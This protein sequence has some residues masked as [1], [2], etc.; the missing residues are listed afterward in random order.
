MKLSQIIRVDEEKCVNCHQCISVCPVKYCNNASG[1]HIKINSDLCIGCGQCIKACSHDARIGLDDFDIWMEDQK[2]GKN[3]V[4]IVAPA[5][6][7]NFPNQYLNIN[8]WLKSLGVKAI[9]DVSFGAELTVKSYLEHVKNNSPECVIAQP[10][11]AL[12]SYIEIYKPEL[13]EYLAPADSPM[14]HTLKMIKNYYPDYSNSKL[15]IISPC[16]T[17]KREFDAVGIGDYNVTMKKISEYFD[18]NNV[19]LSKF[20][21]DDYDNPPAER[22]VLFS[23]PGGLMRTAIRENPALMNVTR[24][25]EGPEIIYEYLNDLKSNIKNKTAPLLIDCLNCDMGCNGGTGTKNDKSIDEVEYLI[26]KRNIEMQDNYKSSFLKKPSVR[27][28]R[29]TVN[30][31]WKEGI[32]GRKYTDLSTNFS[33]SIKSPTNTDV[34][35]IYKSMHK[36]KPEDIKNCSACGYDTCEG[37]AVAIHNG[38]NDKHN[39][40]VY[41]EKMDEYISR[42][43]EE[44]SKFSEGDLNV[45]FVDEGNNEAAKLF[46]ELNISVGNI[47]NMIANIKG[48]IENISQTSNKLSSSSEEMSNGAQE[49]REQTESVAVAVDEMTHTI[50]ATTNNASSASGKS[51]HAGSIAKTGGEVVES[52]VEGMNR[53]AAVVS[54]SANIIKELGKNSDHIGEIVQVINDIADQTNLLALNAAIEAARAGEDGR[55]FAVVAD[56]VRKLAGR[57]TNATKEIAGMIQQVQKDTNGAVKSIEV[58]TKEVENGILLA[59]KAGESLKEIITSTDEVVDVVNQVAAAS[60][61]QSVTSEQISKNI[62]SI[63]S[64]TQQ[65]V[66]GIEEIVR[67]SEGLNDLTVSLKNMIS[68]F[69]VDDSV[70]RRIDEGPFLENNLN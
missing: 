68:M 36:T 51:I 40:H 43:L 66:F 19:S 55:G 11:P 14:T 16:I 54:E 69:K 52:T 24:K 34:D 18:D 8:G 50:M 61:Q 13:I 45:H 65:S 57:T 64:V 39:C 25:I 42:N 63:S 38:L 4:A 46:K 37:M 12:V 56:E 59:S 58:G 33:S 31:Y 28:I 47:R 62:E 21:K 67:V 9:F 30:A 5:I 3:V 32:Y 23:T 2:S 1:D 53:I 22:A 6:A 10:C 41:L 44:V 26:E 27:K 48:V 17:K 15:L 35:A 70:K 7:A 49:Q 29:K 20:P 60:E